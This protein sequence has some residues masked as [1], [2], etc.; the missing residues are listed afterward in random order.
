MVIHSTAPLVLAA[1]TSNEVGAMVNASPTLNDGIDLL[2]SCMSYFDD[3]LISFKSESGKLTTFAMF[4]NEP[5][6]EDFY[7]IQCA[8][9]FMEL[10]GSWPTAYIDNSTF[11]LPPEF[12]SNS[13]R[14]PKPFSLNTL[15]LPLSSAN[16]PSC[17]GL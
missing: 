11:N 13:E 15:G 1:S 6:D 10:V 9:I 4:Y 8:A 12:P 7:H 3:R 2:I 17:V 14:P 16:S 5:L